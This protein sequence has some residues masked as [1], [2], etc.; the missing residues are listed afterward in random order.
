MLY[1]TTGFILLW[2]FAAF[3]QTSNLIS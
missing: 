1:T 2:S 3:Q